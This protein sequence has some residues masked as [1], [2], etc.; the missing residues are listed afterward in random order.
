MKQRPR[1]GVADASRAN[2]AAE[3][4]VRAF[5]VLAAQQDADYQPAFTLAAV[6]LTGPLGV[7]CAAAMAVS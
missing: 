5:Q 1:H 7:D 3:D 6:L 2:L 4:M